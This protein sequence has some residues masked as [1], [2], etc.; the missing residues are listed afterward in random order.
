MSGIVMPSSSES[1][2]NGTN[3]VL[4]RVK[5]FRVKVGKVSASL[6]FA[7]HAGHVT[8]VASELV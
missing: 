6:S 7:W 4:P 8:S 1:D 3:G 2:A 5:S